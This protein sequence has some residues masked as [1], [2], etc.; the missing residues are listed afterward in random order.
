[1]K[2]LNNENNRIYNEEEMKEEYNNQMKNDKKLDNYS[3][4]SYE[5]W[6][7]SVCSYNGS[8]EEITE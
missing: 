3:G 4:E 5:E 6:K 1:M 7:N 8:F 2:Y